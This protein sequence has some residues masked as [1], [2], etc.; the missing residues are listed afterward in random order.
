MKLICQD[1]SEIDVMSA[2]MQDGITS[3]GDMR[4]QKSQRRFVVMFTRFMWEETTGASATSLGKSSG[5][6]TRCGIHFNDVLSVNLRD[7]DQSDRSGLLSLLALKVEARDENFEIELIFAGR[8]SI[9]L[10]A[11]AI[12]VNLS[13]QGE[14]WATPNRPDHDA[15]S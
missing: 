4:L 15:G 3:L 12:D 7:I 1:S 2:C 13:D 8:G 5:R 14:P 9:K 10:L 6:R 11:E